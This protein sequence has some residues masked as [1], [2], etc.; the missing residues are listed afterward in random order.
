MCQVVELKQQYDG[1]AGDPCY[2]SKGS[3]T[4]KTCRVTFT[5]K[6][7]MK[8]PVYVYYE[9][10]NFYQNHR[11]YVKSRSDAQLKGDFPNAP[12]TDCDPLKT[13]PPDTNHTKSRKL[14]PCGLIANSMFNGASALSAALRCCRGKAPARPDVDPARCTCV[15][16]CRYVHVGVGRLGDVGEGHRVGV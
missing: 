16:G 7:E 4:P 13:V 12:T 10:D 2:I 15:V 8:K 6:E 14:W 3:Y 1:D 9:L 5:V 11:R